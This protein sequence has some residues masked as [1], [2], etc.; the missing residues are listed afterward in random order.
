[1]KAAD[2]RHLQ[3]LTLLTLARLDLP[4][5]RRL[6][7]QAVMGPVLMIVREEFSAESS[8]I[9]F[10]ERDHMIQQLSTTATHPALSDSVLPRAVNA[11]L[12]WLDAATR[13][14]LADCRIELRIVIEDDNIC[15]GRER[16]GL[17]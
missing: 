15:K 6:F 5:R 17:T 1:M 4:V 12:D 2:S 13:Q 14:E 11:R 3:K 9:L 10:V 8:Q 7:P 16:E